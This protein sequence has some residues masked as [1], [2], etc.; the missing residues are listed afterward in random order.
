MA[1]NIDIHEEEDTAPDGYF[2]SLEGNFIPSEWEQFYHFVKFGKA[3]A[4][5]RKVF[6]DDDA[7]GTVDTAAAAYLQPIS[8]GRP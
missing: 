8:G 7:I 2:T 6:E 1:E 5:W 4:A 3:P